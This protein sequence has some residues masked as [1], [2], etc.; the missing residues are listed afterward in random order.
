MEGSVFGSIVTSCVQIYIRIP[1]K[2]NICS[3]FSNELHLIMIIYS[4]VVS[5]RVISCVKYNTKN[6][7]DLQRKRKLS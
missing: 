6:C 2:Y 1:W 3:C 4:S 7:F 5:K